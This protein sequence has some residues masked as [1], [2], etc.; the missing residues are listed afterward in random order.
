MIV[1]DPEAEAASRGDRSQEVRVLVA[2]DSP[3]YHRLVAD[4]LFY[5]PY[6]LLC[7]KSGQEALDLFREH[8]PQIVI[9]DWMMPDL[10][11]PELCKKIRECSHSAYTYV[12]LLTSMADSDSLVKGLEAGADE[13]LTKPFDPSELQARLGVG[14]RI[15]QLHQQVEAKDKQ[16][17]KSNRVDPLTGLPNHHAIEEWVTWQLKSAADH[18]FPVWLVAVDIDSF[19][20]INEAFGREAGDTVLKQFSEILVD[21]SRPSEMCSRIGDDEFCIGLTHSSKEELI[22]SMERLRLRLSGKEFKF[23]SKIVATTAAFG[24]VGFEGTAAPEFAAMLRQAENA[25]NAAKQAGGNQFR[26]LNL[27]ATK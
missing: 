2:D 13:F 10:T 4:A 15:V 11:G 7:A 23:G 16:L 18:R 3:V 9:T 12:I 5:Q 22:A 19:R 17:E 24:A 25:V 6:T 8:S 1:L 21:A 14:R 26:M 20:A 27:P